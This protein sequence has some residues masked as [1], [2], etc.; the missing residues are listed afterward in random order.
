MTTGKLTERVR[1]E[2]R[3]TLP[4]DPEG[5]PSGAWTAYWECWAGFQPEFAREVLSAGRMEATMRGVLTVRR[6]D[7]ANG[8]TPSDR[9]VFI[10]G[11][12]A[13]LTANVGFPMPMRTRDTIEFPVTA[14][15]ADE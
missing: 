15:G 14:G 11:G 12:Y 7:E 1:F 5:A 10:A 3:A 2:R 4:D 13:G 9:L 8:V 6:C